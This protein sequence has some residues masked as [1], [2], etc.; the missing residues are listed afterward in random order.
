VS[1]QQD[2]GSAAD[3][4]L[5]PEAIASA[6]AKMSKEDQ[7]LTLIKASYAN[8]IRVLGAAVGEP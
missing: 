6:L 3:N 1:K 7:T 8:P 2:G 5:S 4:P